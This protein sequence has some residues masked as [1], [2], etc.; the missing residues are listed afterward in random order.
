MGPALN[1]GSR[2]STSRIHGSTGSNVNHRRTHSNSSA[3]GA[4]VG[5]S[6]SSVNPSFRFED[7]LDA[8]SYLGMMNASGHQ[9]RVAFD[10][11]PRSSTSYG[12]SNPSTPIY[13]HGMTRQNSLEVDRSAASVSR[14]FCLRGHFPAFIGCM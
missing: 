5:S 7:E 3:T 2:I 12:S 9:Q 10:L 4:N 8:A 13:R 11:D 6:T 1:P 14:L